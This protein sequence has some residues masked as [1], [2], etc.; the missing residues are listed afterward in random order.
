MSLKNLNITMRYLDVIIPVKNE[1]DNVEELVRRIHTSLS[2]ADIS[3]GIIFVDDHSDDATVDVI[4]SLA[5]DFPI[6]AYRKQGKKGKA[7]SILEGARYSAAD[8]LVMIDGDLQYPPEA[9]P[10]MFE[11]SRKHGIVVAKRQEYGGSQTR[12]F[13]SNS[14]KF[15][16]G[17]M[18]FNFQCDV[19]SGLK[20]FK[21]EIIDVLQENEVSGWTL[22]IPLLHTAMQMGHSIG[23]K[24]YKKNSLFDRPLNY[25]LSYLYSKI[26]SNIILKINLHRTYSKKKRLSFQVNSF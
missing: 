2:K 14:F 10:L 11:K 21:R 8:T 9:I 23:G 6:K 5:K 26:H 24:K 13:I 3:Y 12:K 4:N 19:Q 18:L 7:Y 1:A 15:L 22:D 17:K 25:Y 20:L 16:F